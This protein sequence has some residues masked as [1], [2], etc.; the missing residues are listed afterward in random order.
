MC[1]ASYILSKLQCKLELS[2]IEAQVFDDGIHWNIVA[3][4]NLLASGSDL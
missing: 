3:R 4:S 1:I 2:F